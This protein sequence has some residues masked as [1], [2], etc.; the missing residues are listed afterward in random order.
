MIR[1]VSD[2]VTK[3][4]LSRH[5]GILEGARVPPRY[6]DLIE[7]SSGLEYDHAS[8]HYFTRDDIATIERQLKLS[9]WCNSWSVASTP[10][11]FEHQ[12]T[13]PKTIE[14]SRLRHLKASSPSKNNISDIENDSKEQRGSSCWLKNILTSSY[15]W[16]EHLATIAK[17]STNLSKTQISIYFSETHFASTS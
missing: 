4:P 11:A 3:G 6:L 12:G 10:Q 17:L 14:S 2:C 5:R 8:Y 7:V 15:E 1:H 9:I 16:Q 13:R